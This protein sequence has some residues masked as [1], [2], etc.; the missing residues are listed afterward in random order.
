MT[1]YRKHTE[2]AGRGWARAFAGVAMIV[3]AHSGADDLPPGEL[4]DIGTHRMHLNCTGEGQPTVV[5]DAGL[6]GSMLDWS[7]VQP[8]V[9]EYTEVC[10]YD[11]SG[12]GWSESSSQPRSS[13]YIADELH[14][15]LARGGVNPPYL[16]IGHSFGGFNVRLFAA[17]YPS[18]VTGIVLIDASHEAQFERFEQRF[19][20]NLA[21]KRAGMMRLSP[22]RVPDGM[23]ESLRTVALQRVRR[24]SAML[25]VREELMR[26][27]E[28]AEQVK[29]EP[30]LLDV[31]LVVITRG[32]PQWRNLPNGAALE[33]L[34]VEL[35]HSLTN[36]MTERDHIIAD[37]SGHYVHLDQPQLVDDAIRQVVSRTRGERP[38]W[39]MLAAY[40][41]RLY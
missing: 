31:P 23:P 16:M 13:A 14:E 19:G 20:L 22:P 38:D 8:L 11:R 36:L 41:A 18:E 27:R 25:A 15:L 4:I 7:L 10:S 9:S 39:Q 37:R 26:F 3:A 34:W 28:S 30:V 24:A 2:H 6:G 12:Y 35:Q 21:P 29:R 32:H 17:H 40:G 5:M 1:S 33:A